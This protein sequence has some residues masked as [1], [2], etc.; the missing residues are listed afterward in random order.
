LIIV[1]TVGGAWRRGAALLALGSIALGLGAGSASAA[2]VKP[3]YIA[4]IGG[5]GHAEIY[6]GGVAVDSTGIVYVADTGNDQVKAY[7][8]NGAVKWT[9]GVRGP[10]KLGNFDNPRDIAYLAGKLYVADLGYKRV[11][12][13]DA[14][15]GAPI[16]PQPGAWGSVV[17]PS[18]IGISAGVDQNGASV[19]LVSQDTKNQVSEYTTGGSFIR[20]IGSTTAGSGDGQLKAPRDAATDS[21]GNI[22]VVDYGNDRISKFSATGV[23]VK[24]WGSSGGQDGQF[25]RPYGVDLDVNNN[26][27]VA[28]STNHRIQVF[29]PNGTF[30]AKYGSD[31]TG[32]G[33]R[34][35]RG[36]Q[37]QRDS[38]LLERR[39][40]GRK[41]PE[42]AAGHGG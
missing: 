14:S 2:P 41:L 4:T 7:W 5:P 23:F 36:H 25:R 15:T 17:L 28:D 24:N 39:A 12:V 20:N 13:L 3:A 35:R 16:S 30:L 33:A 38:V 21:S 37:D 22:Y 40:A 26:I 1:R 19:I 10:K 11:Q 27:Y 42:D 18:P 32:G 31:G 29:N 9:Q 34:R 8:P 6:P